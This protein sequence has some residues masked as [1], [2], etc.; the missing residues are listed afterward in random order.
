MFNGMMV[1]VKALACGFVWLWMSATVYAS[2]TVPFVARVVWV[3]GAFQ[4]MAMNGESRPLLGGAQIYLHDTLITDN[5]SEAQVVFTD[6]TLMTFRP[7]SNFYIR[8]YSYQ[9]PTQTQVKQTLGNYAVSL[10]TGGF[11]TITGLIAKQNPTHYEVKTP[12]ATIGVRGTDYSV[13]LLNGQLFAGRRAGAIYV[14]SGGKKLELN[15]NVPYARVPAAHLPPVPLV[16][17]PPALSH[18]LPLTQTTYS[19]VGN[20]GMTPPPGVPPVE[21][22]GGAPPPPAS[23]GDAPSAGGST[24]SSG[25]EIPPPSSPP[26][27]GNT[28]P[29]PSE[30]SAPPADGGSIFSTS[31]TPSTGVG[32][33][34][35]GGT[36]TQSICIGR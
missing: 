1:M 32:T 12:V 7:S 26:S 31:P 29:P 4:A 36:T 19:A 9:T 5:H 35:T 18:Q 23:G 11:R 21:D 33:Q 25:G 10:I 6:N 17:Q 27:G 34:A 8:D 15:Q 16:K 24:P 2:E 3:K 30:G 13:R 22:G 28:P 20:S 14:F